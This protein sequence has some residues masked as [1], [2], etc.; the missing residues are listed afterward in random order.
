ML[1][2]EETWI[3]GRHYFQY[4][5]GERGQETDQTQV[6]RFECCG[7]RSVIEIDLCLKTDWVNLSRRSERKKEEEAA[8]AKTPPR[9]IKDRPEEEVKDNSTDAKD[10]AEEGSKTTDVKDDG[11][12]STKVS[13]K[14]HTYCINIFKCVI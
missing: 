1:I 5:A 6:W 4:A 7:K 13:F 14:I 2:S 8:A 11:A 3:L 10:K 9:E 12:V